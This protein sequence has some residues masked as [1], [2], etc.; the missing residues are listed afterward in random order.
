MKPEDNVSN[1][2]NSNK[3]TTGFNEQYLD[4]MKNKSRICNP[5]D[6]KYQGRRK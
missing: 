4:A 3:G 5:T 6:V 2:N 1:M